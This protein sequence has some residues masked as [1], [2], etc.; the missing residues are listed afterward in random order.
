MYVKFVDLQFIFC[1]IS[2]TSPVLLNVYVNC[3][4][5][6]YVGAGETSV[7]GVA[8]ESAMWLV[9]CRVCWIFEFC[10]N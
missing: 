8:A 7:F 10:P 1:L 6:F 3:S 9:G 4:T 2:R 5:I